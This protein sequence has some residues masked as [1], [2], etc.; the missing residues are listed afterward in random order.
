MSVVVGVTRARNM[1]H[2]LT[3]ISSM[4]TR[5]ILAELAASYSAETGRAVTVTSIGGV[6][7][8][9]RIKSGEPFDVVVLAS[10]ALHRLAQDGFVRA[11]SVAVFAR[12]ATAVAVRSGTRRPTPCDEASVKRM[13]LEARAIGISTGP[14]GTRL[15]KLI[16]DWAMGADMAARLVEAP[17]GVPVARLIACGEVDV[18]FQQL[19]ELEGEPDIDLVGTLPSALVPLTDFAVGQATSSIEAAALI[20]YLLSKH[21]R[22][23]LSRHG[24]Q[25]T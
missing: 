24:L 23:A 7:A 25:P 18:G 3:V 2:G 14:S 11:D 17:P 1:T 19:S 5:R 12:S 8:A 10:D 16:D 9:R 6:E 13:L 22:E 21:A 20:G 15:R 4:A